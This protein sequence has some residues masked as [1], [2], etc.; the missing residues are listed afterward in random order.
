MRFRY[1]FLLG[2]SMKLS[3]ILVVTMRILLYIRLNICSMENW[4]VLIPGSVT[5]MRGKRVGIS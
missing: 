5:G 3:C 2:R 4:S 1:G